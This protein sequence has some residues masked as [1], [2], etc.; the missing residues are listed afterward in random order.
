[1]SQAAIKTEV[2]AKILH[3]QN[4]WAAF[5]TEGWVANI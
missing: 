2:M 5:K 3:G 4:E 1:M